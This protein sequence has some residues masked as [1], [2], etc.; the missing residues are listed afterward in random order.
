MKQCFCLFM[1]QIL[2]FSSSSFILIPENLTSFILIPE[3][4]SYI[5]GCGF[6]FW[7]LIK[8]WRKMCKRI[9]V[10]NTHICLGPSVLSILKSHKKISR[11]KIMSLGHHPAEVQVAKLYPNY[12]LHHVITK[13]ERKGLRVCR[14]RAYNFRFAPGR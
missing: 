10:F 8:K 12:W 2:F 13:R 9:S 4:W 14:Q 3:I 11:S 5:D 6:R 7:I 1:R